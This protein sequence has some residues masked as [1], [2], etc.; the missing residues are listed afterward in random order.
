[1]GEGGIVLQHAMYWVTGYLSKLQTYS[2]SASG[3]SAGM[4]R[5]RAKAA[6]ALAPA[7][8]PAHLRPRWGAEAGGSTALNFNLFVKLPWTLHY[9]KISLQT[10][11]SFPNA[12]WTWLEM[13]RRIVL[14]CTNGMIRIVIPI[15]NRDITSTSMRIHNVL[16]FV[17]SKMI[18]IIMQHLETKFQN[19]P[20]AKSFWHLKQWFCKNSLKNNN[21]MNIKIMSS[22]SNFHP[23]VT[24]R[25]I[26]N[27]YTSSLH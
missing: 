26:F 9:R 4:Q 14:Y 6:P 25:S 24:K 16:K 2:V 23:P 17:S 5:L 10:L 20:G 8:L 12:H 19:H 18:G 7:H 21:C 1:M 22:V 3:E 11:Y 13:G 15:N 27:F